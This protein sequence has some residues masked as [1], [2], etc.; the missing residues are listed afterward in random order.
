MT[1]ALVLWMRNPV[2]SKS[3]II[4]VVRV[5]RPSGNNT[6]RPPLAKN[7]AMRLAP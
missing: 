5:R 7:S 4:R 2:P 3:F 6:K 1:F